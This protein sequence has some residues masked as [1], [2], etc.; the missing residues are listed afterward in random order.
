[1]SEWVA[2]GGKVKKVSRRTGMIKNL[3]MY[4]GAM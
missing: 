1:V 3:V 2:S 4:S